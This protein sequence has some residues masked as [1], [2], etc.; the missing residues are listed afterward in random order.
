VGSAGKY[1]AQNINRLEVG[2]RTPGAEITDLGIWKAKLRDNQ[3]AI[4]EQ[5][6]Q[7][8]MKC[9]KMAYRAWHTRGKPLYPQQPSTLAIIKKFK[10]KRLRTS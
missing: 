1:P 8:L 3:Q 2:V 5:R 7:T 9:L 4:K 6:P 10:G